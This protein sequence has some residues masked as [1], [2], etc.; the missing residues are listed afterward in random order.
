MDP[1][2]EEAAL[3]REPALLPLLFQMNQPPLPF[4]EVQVLQAGD[5][6]QIVFLKHIRPAPR[7]SEKRHRRGLF[8]G[9]RF[10]TPRTF[11]P[12][13]SRSPESNNWCAGA[14]PRA[15]SCSNTPRPRTDISPRAAD[16]STSNMRVR[17]SS[18]KA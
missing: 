13:P 4:T 16:R 11:G 7:P 1:L 12:F 17:A 14:L 9:R 2:V 18:N 15:D 10:G 3:G 8:P 6:E 5:R